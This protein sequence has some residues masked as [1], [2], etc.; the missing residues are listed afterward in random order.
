M[1]ESGPSVTFALN[2]LCGYDRTLPWLRDRAGTHFLH[3]IPDEA[4]AF[5]P[6]EVSRG[7]IARA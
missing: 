1:S 5:E 7:V 6:P 2:L 3:D 4:I